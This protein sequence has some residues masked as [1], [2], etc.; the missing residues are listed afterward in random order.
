MTAVSRDF[1]FFNISFRN[2][3]IIFVLGR[4]LQTPHKPNLTPLGLQSASISCS[5]NIFLG[6]HQ[7]SSY[8]GMSRGGMGCCGSMAAGSTGE[9]TE[10]EG[11]GGGRTLAELAMRAYMWAALVIFITTVEGMCY[12][13]AY[14]L[15]QS[16]IPI[17]CHDNQHLAFAHLFK[18][19]CQRDQVCVPL[20]TGFPQV[21]ENT[22]RAGLCC[23]VVQI[24]EEKKQGTSLL[25][26]LIWSIEH[27][28][29]TSKQV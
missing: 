12:L 25:K 3:I 2:I 7:V 27:N 5:F 18:C 6:D 9:G 10:A 17:C 11:R 21:Q 16:T 15:D 13:F 4:R 22:C 14:F 24:P 26:Y 20:V 28:S 19:S 29:Y 23:K 1:F 8:Y